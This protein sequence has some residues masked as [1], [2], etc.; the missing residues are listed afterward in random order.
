VQL[1][2]A[3]IRVL[4]GVR[5]GIVAGS[6]A[7]SWW[8]PIFTSYLMQTN[9]SP[10][11]INKIKLLMVEVGDMPGV[12]RPILPTRKQLEEC[13]WP[14]QVIYKHGDGA[15]G[16]DSYPL[17][18]LSHAFYPFHGGN[19]Y[20]NSRDAMPVQPAP[21]WEPSHAAPIPQVEGRSYA[22]YVDL[23]LESLGFRVG[24][25]AEDEDMLDVET[26]LPTWLRVEDEEGFWVQTETMASGPTPLHQIEWHYTP[27]GGYS[28]ALFSHWIH[29]PGQG[30]RVQFSLHHH[31]HQGD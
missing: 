30:Q 29:N 10:F 27:V 22:S 1:P 25:M 21:G 18:F 4:L 31:L 2:D 12:G 7:Y 9:L 6:T 20:S 15:T 28:I 16:P 14:A 13:G 26:L 5:K 11:Q 19:R 17:T 8:L 3:Q 24:Y 23:T